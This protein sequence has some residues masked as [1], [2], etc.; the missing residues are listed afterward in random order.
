MVGEISVDWTKFSETLCQ[1][2]ETIL[3]PML[4]DTIEIFGPVNTT[5]VWLGKILVCGPSASNLSV[6]AKGL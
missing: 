4:R 3:L 2:T 6:V 5:S 1:A